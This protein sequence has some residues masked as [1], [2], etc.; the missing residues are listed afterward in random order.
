VTTDRSALGIITGSGPEAGL[1]LW[2]KILESNRIALGNRFRGD[3]DA[4]HMVV[5]SDPSL[6]LSMDLTTHRNRVWR[7]LSRCCRNIASQVDYF[8][9]ACNTL[10]AFQPDIEALQ[11]PARLVS[12]VDTAIDFVRVRSIPS[13][14]LLGADPVARLDDLSPYRRLRDYVTVE[15]P[16]PGLQQLIFDIKRSGPTPEL[17]ARLRTI[18]AGLKS[19]VVLLACTELP[20]LDLSFEDKELVDVTAL[21][22]DR[23]ARL[24]L[25]AP[26]CGAA[27]LRGRASR[28]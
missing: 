3:I 13:V 16:A 22:A 15:V 26:A 9:V 12:L 11:L 25:A 19:R 2:E 21:L 24:A 6:G 27:S 5:V 4:P 8:A 28:D 17:K 18:V 20:L 23:M 10:H 7:S 1:D 14:A